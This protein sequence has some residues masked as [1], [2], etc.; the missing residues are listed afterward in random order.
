MRNFAD[1]LDEEWSY[2]SVYLDQWGDV[3]RLLHNGTL[4]VKNFRQDVFLY[5]LTLAKE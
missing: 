5:Y 3:R 1:I 4:T 2:L